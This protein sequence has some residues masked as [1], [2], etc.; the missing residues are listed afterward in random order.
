MDQEWVLAAMV[1]NTILVELLH[2]MLE[3]VAVEPLQHLLV[4]V[5]KAGLAVV[6]LVHIQVMV[7][8]QLGILAVAVALLLR[9]QGLPEQMPEMAALESSSFVTQFN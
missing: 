1:A 9:D 7:R 3:E 6:V 5:V 8:T 2:T 4:L